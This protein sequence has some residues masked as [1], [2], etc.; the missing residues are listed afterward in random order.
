MVDFEGFLNRNGYADD[1]L[2]NL[3]EGEYEDTSIYGKDNKLA[4]ERHLRKYLN[5]YVNR[6]DYKANQLNKLEKIK[7]DPKF[8]TSTFGNARNNVLNAISKVEESNIYLTTV[9]QQK[10]K[11]YLKSKF[12]LSTAKDKE[13]AKAKIDYA[14]ELD[15]RG[16]W[17]AAAA[18]TGSFLAEGGEGFLTGMRDLVNFGLDITGFDLAVDKDRN[19]Q[20]EEQLAKDSSYFTSITDAKTITRDGIEYAKDSKGNIYNVSAGYNVSGVITGLQLEGLDKEI[21]SKGV[22]KNHTSLRGYLTVGGNVTGNVISQVVGQKGFGAVTKA[23]K[24][25]TLASV[26]GFKSVKDYKNMVNLSKAIGGKAKPSFRI[27]VK[28]ST[29]DAM[30]FQGSYGGA[31]GYNNTLAQAKAAGFNDADAEA[32]AYDAGQYM[33]VWYAATGPISD[34]TTWL[35]KVGGNLGI[36][37]IISNA[38]SKTRK[39]SVKNFSQSLKNQL[40]NLSYKLK[41]KGYDFAKEGGKETLQEN[42]QQSGEFL[43]INPKLNTKAKVDFLQDTYSDDEIISTSVL[44]FATGGLLSQIKVPSFK[45]N[46]NAQIANY[47][48][49]AKNSAKAELELDRLVSSG[50]A[51]QEE[52]DQIMFNSKAILNQSPKIPKWLN[53]DYVLNV[54][55]LMQQKQ[56]LENQ[57]KSMNTQLFKS[58]NYSKIGLLIILGFGWMEKVF[59][60]QGVPEGIFQMVSKNPLTSWLT[61][62]GPMGPNYFLG[63]FELIV[64]IL[65][66]VKEKYGDERRSM[67]EYAGGD[68]SI[69]DMIP[70]E[71]VVITISH[72]GYIKRTS[73]TEYRTQNRGGVGQKAST[74]RN[75]DFLEHLFVGT[76]HQYM[77]FFTQ[78]GKCFWMRVYEIPEGSKTSK[79]R[80]I[81]NLINIEQDD[82]VKAFICT[83]D[84]K[85]EDYINSQFVIMA[86]KKGQVKKTSLEQYSRPRTNGIN[87]ITIKE[88]DELL[89]AKLTTGASQVMIALKSGK[90]IRFEEAKTRP[91]GRGASGVRGITLAHETDEVIGMISFDAEDTETAKAVDTEKEKALKKAKEKKFAEQKGPIEP[92]SKEDIQFVQAMNLLKGLP[93]ET[94]PDT[95][96]KTDKK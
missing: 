19:Y 22:K 23:A 96:E 93:V 46:A 17:Y 32:L 68:L 91:M 88:D 45:P 80:A 36:Q 70:N 66:I 35:D 3:K 30:L 47:T 11:D 40:T 69:E 63:Y 72:A 29:V 42:L 79:G 51:T 77:L 84:L 50:F 38:L 87:A 67:I 78:K 52:A 27:P 7:K 92:T 37:K 60:W 64:F 53:G 58:F 43:W 48:Y 12:T 44:S 14:K 61:I 2:N 18:N 71:Q 83:Q 6:Q 74:T 54:A 16:D 90:A 34:R 26:N 86:T 5:L 82:K 33:A 13:Y 31:I 73:L 55:Q 10:Q 85:D 8:K 57:K 49:I 62:L 25:R 94:T 76:N 24:L 21:E 15:Q 89:E 56:D 81:Q 20:A 41:S 39:G 65:L 59:A 1:Y 4:E 9:D 75:E 95:P 28:K